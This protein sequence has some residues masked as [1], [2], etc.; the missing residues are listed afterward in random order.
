V[1]GG[2]G[3]A[4]GTR[5]AAEAAV[6]AWRAGAPG[7]VELET[8]A[9]DGEFAVTLPGERKLRTTVSLIVGDRALSA[10]AF[11]IRHPDENEAEF[12]RWLLTRN[13]RMP[14]ISFAVD[15]HGDVYLVGRLPLAAVTEDA[16]DEL[17]GA[18]L[19]ASDGAFNDLLAIGFISSM[20]KEWAWRVDRGESTRNLEAFR[21]LLEP[22]P[23]DG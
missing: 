22:T 19:S 11:V 6:L 5:E 21:H 10:S 9:R 1:S 12:Y 13:L 3:P 23:K 18:I 15:A 20:R 14:G 8:G 2:G 16:V 17:L 7:E 4:P